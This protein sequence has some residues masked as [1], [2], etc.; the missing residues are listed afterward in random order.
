[1]GPAISM[2]GALVSTSAVL[3]S[4]PDRKV[5]KLTT[6]F[7]SHPPRKLLSDLREGAVIYDPQG[8]SHCVAQGQARATN[9]LGT[10]GQSRAWAC[11]AVGVSG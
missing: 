3:S 4:M 11:G 6:I 5:L 9:A 8:H 10:R 7:P 2:A 1:M